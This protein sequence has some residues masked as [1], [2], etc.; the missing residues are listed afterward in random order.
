MYQFVAYGGESNFSYPARP[1]DPK[2]AWNI[3]WTVKVRY[4][5]ATGGMLGMEDPYGSAG[6]DD[7]ADSGAAD[8]GKGKKSRKPKGSDLLRGLGV[9]IPGM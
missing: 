9:P 6:D 1:A 8:S 4:R 3:E 2:V 5:S 7:G